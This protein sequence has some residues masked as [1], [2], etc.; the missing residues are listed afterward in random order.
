MYPGLYAYKATADRTA[1]IF[2]DGDSR[3]R[4]AV[5]KKKRLR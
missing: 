5:D 3:F 4:K 1:E 2:A